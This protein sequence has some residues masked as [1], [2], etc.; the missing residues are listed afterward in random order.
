MEWREW[1][2]PVTLGTTVVAFAAGSS[3]V[4]EVRDVGGTVR[5]L[6][7]FVLAAV[8]VAPLVARRGRGI[9]RPSPLLAAPLAALLA[10]AF[11]SAVWS[12]DPPLTFARTTSFAVLLGRTLETR[13]HRTGGRSP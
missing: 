3:S 10:L 13:L 5:W 12:V 2:A 11:L 6:A 9:P 8:A 1:L 7:L 4:R